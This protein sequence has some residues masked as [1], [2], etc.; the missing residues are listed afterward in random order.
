[1]KTFTLTTGDKIPALGLGTWKSAPEEVGSAVREAVK[2]GYRHLDCA[3]I[4]ENEKEIGQALAG[5]RGQVERDRLWITSKL[6]NNAHRPELVRPALEKTLSDL[7]LDYLDLFLIHWP[8]VFRPGV[9]FPASADDFVS[10]A[11]VP[12]LD[13]WRATEECVAAGLARTIGVSNFSRKKLVELLAAARIPPV[14]NQVEAH[15]FLQQRGLLDF[16]AEH[17]ILLTAYSPL[18]SGDRAAILKKPDE[19]S[20]FQ[21]PLI[22]GI[23][24]RHRATPAQVLLAWAMQR[25]TAVIPKSI[26][27]ERLQQNLAAQAL[28]LT[29]EEM[30]AVGGLDRG[31]R[32]VDGS[33]WAMPGSP[34]TLDNLWDGECDGHQAGC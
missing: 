23:A 24:A 26:H 16:C 18:G 1:M 3:P 19:P 31:Y 10:L 13:T 22:Q 28:T 8:V 21:L 17:Q 32:F 30:V 6:W 33:F 27:P 7:R 34:Y 9:Q 2:L 20:L 29:T 15:P 12:I 14:V 4:Y 25:G 5:M 11:H